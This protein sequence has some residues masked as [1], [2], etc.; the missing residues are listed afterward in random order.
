[1]F[2]KF[3]GFV[4]GFLLAVFLMGTA[5]TASAAGNEVTITAFLSNVKLKLNGQDWTPKDSV[6]GEYYKPITYNGRTYLPLRAVVEEAAK[7][8]VDYDSATQTV[9]IGGKS[10]VF[11]IKDTSCYENYFGTIITTDTAKLATPGNAYQWG[12]TNEKEVNMQYFTCYL[13]P[14]GNY[15]YF[16]A[17]FFMDESAKDNL[18]INIRKDNN[19]GAVIKSLIIKPG[20]TL[21]DINADIGGME[22]I[23]IESNVRIN[24]GNIKKLVIGEPIFYNGTL[25]DNSPTR[26]DS[27]VR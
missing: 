2:E 25:K 8:P 19:N 15:K 18:T 13:K 26:D 20:E 9:W 27:T 23:C 3:K 1:M 17:S 11:Q 14:N 10:D 16:R 7:M 24:H 5:L 6:T 12:I 4:A 21:A 22:K